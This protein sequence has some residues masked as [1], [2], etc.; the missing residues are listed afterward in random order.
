MWSLIVTDEEKLIA[1]RSY[2]VGMYPIFRPAVLLP[3][4]E[5]AYNRGWDQATYEI[6]RDLMRILDD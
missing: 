1:I 3:P 5:M 2:V 6:Q 4:E